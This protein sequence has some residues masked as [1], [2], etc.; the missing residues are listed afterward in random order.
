M[1]SCGKL[2]AKCLLSLEFTMALVD[3]APTWIHHPHLPSVANRCGREI[4]LPCAIDQE[5]VQRLE[6]E[7]TKEAAGETFRDFLISGGFLK[8]KTLVD[9]LSP[10]NCLDIRGFSTVHEVSQLTKS[11]DA[12]IGTNFSRMLNEDQ[13]ISLPRV[14]VNVDVSAHLED[15]DTRSLDCHV[16]ERIVPAVVRE[17]SVHSVSAPSPC[18]FVEEKLVMM[19]LMSDLS[20]QMANSK[21]SKP[22]S[23]SPEKPISDYIGLV[24][25][26]PS[27]VRRLH[28]G[29]AKPKSCNEEESAAWEILATHT[30]GTGAVSVVRC[31]GE[32]LVLNVQMVSKGS[33]P[34]VICPISPTTGV[35]LAV[36]DSFFSQMV[37]SRSGFGLASVG[38]SLMSVGGYGRGGVLRDCECFDQSA[39]SWVP[40]CKLTTPR[41]RL[42]LV[43][44]KNKMYAIGGSD[45]KAELSSVE[46]FTS[47]S[48]GWEKLPSTLCTA[49]SDFG[50]AVL[51]CRVYAIGGIHY[52][53]L[54]RSAE[55]FDP[56]TKEWKRIAFM[57]TPRRGVAVVSCNDS[58]YAIGGQS[59]SWGCLNSVEC[60]NPLTD[61]WRKVAPM[62]MHRRN[63][64][65]IAIEDRIYVIG[66][67]NGSSA[68]NV[69]EVYDPASDKWASASPMVLKR[70]SA[71]AVLLKGAIYVVGGF[72]GSLFLNSVEK[73]DVM[74]GQWTSYNKS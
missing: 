33:S 66:G 1:T 72:S 5:H 60:Y 28:L 7:S 37:Q 67:Y 15:L 56:I 44:H 19:E 12:Y 18:Q 40:S 49:R 11:C 17:L 58:I 74:S 57:S 3:S 71:A 50:A 59:S 35:P 30:I 2:H 38:D 45:G 25:K 54:L 21:L 61:Q 29:G 51:G 53:N 73:Y 8:L 64:C 14:Q 43:Q 22:L 31:E 42:A 39:N 41:A 16:L 62:V 65:A 13:L 48:K 9:N 4:R 10:Q 68:V 27:P 24:Q 52:S 69:V 63:A 34:N 32:L 70:S 36:S 47:E 23:V 6:I 46:V 26:Q 20:V 55:V